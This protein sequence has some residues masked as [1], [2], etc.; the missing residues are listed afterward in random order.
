MGEEIAP[1][2]LRKQCHVNWPNA[3]VNLVI[4]VSGVIVKVPMAM[5]VVT[6]EEKE[7]GT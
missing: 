3:Y 7:A 6:G 2:N 1:E 4:G 5:D